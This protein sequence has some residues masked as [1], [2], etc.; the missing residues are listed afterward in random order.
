[1]REIFKPKPQE[2]PGEVFYTITRED[3]G[4]SVIDTEAGPVNVS[5]LLGAVLRED[6]GKRLYRVLT[7]QRYYVWQVENK[8]QFDKRREM[9]ARRAPHPR[10]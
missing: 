9:E 3:A 7:P 5:G 4:K 1:M 6:I 2:D 10:P 8:Q